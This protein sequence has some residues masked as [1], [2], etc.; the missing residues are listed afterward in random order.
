MRE[1]PGQWCGKGVCGLTPALKGREG[2]SREKTGFGRASQGDEV[3]LVQ[4][5]LSESFRM[6]A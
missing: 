5:Q 4:T 1:E 2:N 6:K 3:G